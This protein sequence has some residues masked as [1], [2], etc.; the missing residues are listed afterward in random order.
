MRALIALY[1]IIGVVLLGL[2]F[3]ATG[4]CENKNTDV[5]NDTVFVLTWPVTFYDEVLHGRITSTEWL[6]KQACEGG[7]GPHRSVP[8]PTPTPSPVPDQPRQ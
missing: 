8:E 3:F 1:L 2:G 7:I 4:P 5:L 6:H